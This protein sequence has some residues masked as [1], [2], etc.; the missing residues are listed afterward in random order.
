MVPVA[1]NPSGQCC[2]YPQYDVWSSYWVGIN[3]FDMLTASVT[4]QSRVPE[5]PARTIPFIAATG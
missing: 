5:P 1:R 2:N 3:G 4:G